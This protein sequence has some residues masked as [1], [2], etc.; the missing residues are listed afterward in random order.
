M[1][2][3]GVMVAAPKSRGTGSSGEGSHHKILSDVIN[4]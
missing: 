4:I 3:D 1:G 2:G